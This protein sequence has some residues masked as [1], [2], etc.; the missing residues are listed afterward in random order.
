MPA[1]LTIREAADYLKVNVSTI[2]RWCDE[3]RLPFYELE[4]GGGRRFK[5]DD[6][7]A[8]LRTASPVR[9]HAIIQGLTRDDEEKLFSAIERS[10]PTRGWE[11]LGHTP[12]FIRVDRPPVMAAGAVG[13]PRMSNE[14]RIRSWIVA[15]AIDAGI[16]LSLDAVQANIEPTAR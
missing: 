6:L 10:Q 16:Q 11:L 3:G 4:S 9:A 15:A 7:D 1:W 14:L 8:L 2:Y 12:L 5:Q 13:P